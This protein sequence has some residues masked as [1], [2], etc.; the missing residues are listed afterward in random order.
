MKSSH[1]DFRT[2]CL[3]LHISKHALLKNVL[4]ATAHAFNSW[5]YLSWVTML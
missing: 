2:N 4:A 1:T 5:L 3:V